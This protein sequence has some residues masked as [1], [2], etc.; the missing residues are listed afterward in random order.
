LKVALLRI[1]NQIFSH[2]LNPIVVR[3]VVG[4]LR[5]IWEAET[6]CLD[7]DDMIG[8]VLRLEA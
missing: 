3:D 8:C 5:N 2:V 1:C 6:V 7:P 4:W